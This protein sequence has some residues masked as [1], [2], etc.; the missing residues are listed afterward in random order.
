M[1][2]IS[3][4]FY[5][6]SR[7][8][9]SFNIF[10][11]YRCSAKIE[12]NLVYLLISLQGRQ[13]DPGIPSFPIRPLG[14]PDSWQVSISYHPLR[15]NP[16]PGSNFYTDFR[17]IFWTEKCIKNDLFG[18]LLSSL[19][20]VIFVNLKWGFHKMVFFWK[21]YQNWFIFGFSWFDS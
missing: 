17:G 14:S 20:Q 16:I 9:H 2:E 8:T 6:F 1:Q 4:W 7:T 12:L 19:K 11:H 21:S 5:S 13:T 3:I 10:Q 18:A 15:E